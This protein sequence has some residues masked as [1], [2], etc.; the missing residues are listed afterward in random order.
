MTADTLLGTEFTKIL[1]SS[2]GK[3]YH[4]TP[5]D[6]YRLLQYQNWLEQKAYAAIQRLFGGR[7]DEFYRAVS[8]LAASIAQGDYSPDGDIWRQSLTTFDGCVRY[9]SLALHPD[10]H[11]NAEDDAVEITQEEGLLSDFWYQIAG[12]H[13][14]PKVKA[15]QLK[16][17]PITM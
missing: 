7:S 6:L 16:L 9:I 13:T 10:K 12:L 1:T 11:V 15:A 2:S 17:A 8:A 3:Q 5:L 4:I 14:H